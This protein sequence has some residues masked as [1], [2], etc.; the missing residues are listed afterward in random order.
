M[1]SAE[2]L[3][4]INRCLLGIKVGFCVDNVDP[5]KSTNRDDE[6]NAVV[7]QNTKVARDISRRVMK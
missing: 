3:I 2:S 6:G 5:G 4:Q 1:F 7:D